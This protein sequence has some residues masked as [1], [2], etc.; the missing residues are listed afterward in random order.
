MDSV[1]LLVLSKG[2]F[3]G[4]VIVILLINNLMVLFNIGLS[5]GIFFKI[6]FRLVIFFNCIESVSEWF[7]LFCCVYDF[8]FRLINE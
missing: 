4:M 1:R 7:L 8:S 6:L 5:I 2:R 3:I